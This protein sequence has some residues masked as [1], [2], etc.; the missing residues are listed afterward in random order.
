M[1]ERFTAVHGRK[2]V[3]RASAEELGTVSHLLV[4]TQRRRV[5]SLVVGKRRNAQLVDWEDLS[6]L[7]ADAVMVS[8][9]ASLREPRDEREQAAVHGHLELIGRRALSDLGNELGKIHDVTF[10]ADSGALETITVGDHE[11]PANSLLGAGSYAV[12]LRVDDA[13]TADS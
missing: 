9:E 12:I 5:V 4:D 2:V 6:G 7:G 10:D 1:S 11:E 8:D 13:Q 3:S